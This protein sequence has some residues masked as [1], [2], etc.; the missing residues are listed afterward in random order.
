MKTYK[1][2]GCSVI[3]LLGVLEVPS[4]YAEDLK[5]YFEKGN[6]TGNIRA[7]YNTR[8]YEARPDE[9]AFSLGGALRAETGSTG[10]FSLGVGFYTAQDLN[11]NDDDPMKVNGRLGSELEV[12]GEAYVKISSAGH[13]A[14]LGR[15]RIETPF[16]NSGDAFI[17]PFAFEGWSYQFEKSD[18]LDIEVDY[19]NA[20]KN[21]NSDDFVDVG[22]WTSNRFGIAETQTTSGAVNV[23][24]TYKGDDHKVEAWGSR[25][26]EF[27]DQLYLR[28]DYTLGGSEEFKPFVGLQY[29][30][31]K[32]SGDALVGDVSSSI[33]GIQAGAAMG[34]FKLTLGFNMV[35]DQDDNYRNGAFLSPYTFSTSPLFK[36]AGDF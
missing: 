33:Y 30:S 26:S 9:A 22:V 25:F 20:I 21:R 36:Y 18:K 8:E 17:I 6:V 19:I 13:T 15:Q 4:I 14:N 2:F 31:Q 32:D 5:S 24:V 11:T 12:L 28:A 1:C 3:G 16:A 7:Y 34:R 23:G 27:Y 10:L 35:P 29:G